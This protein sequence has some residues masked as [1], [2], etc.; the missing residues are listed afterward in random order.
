MF[1][2]IILPNIFFRSAKTNALYQTM[3]FLTCQ[4]TDLFCDSQQ[5]IFL[6]IININ[7][8]RLQAI[9]CFAKVLETHGQLETNL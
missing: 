2:N 6:I 4:S 8:K 5:S 9:H 3:A 7:N 1:S